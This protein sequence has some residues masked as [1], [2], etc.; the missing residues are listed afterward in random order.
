MIIDFNDRDS[1]SIKPFA[2]KKKD[3]IKA[4]TRFMSGK[5][6]MFPKLSLNSFIYSLCELLYFPRPKVKEIYQKYHIEKN[7]CY[8]IL[9]DTDSTSLQFLVIS[10]PDSDFPESI[11]R[12]VIFEIIV[13]TDIYKRFDTSHSF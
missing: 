1:A 8:H 13:N 2:V 10:D 11:I 7:L 4:T 3:Q 12:D 6:L 9:T 5:L